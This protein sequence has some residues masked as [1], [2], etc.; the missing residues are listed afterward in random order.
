MGLHLDNQFHILKINFVFFYNKLLVET[1]LLFV[2]FKFYHRHVIDHNMNRLHYL[3]ALLLYHC[4]YDNPVIT[5]Q[6]ISFDG[7]RNPLQMC[8]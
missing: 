2:K 6:A 1:L 3:L 8:L 7:L 4:C 5:L